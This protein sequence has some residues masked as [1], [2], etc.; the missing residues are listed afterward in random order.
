MLADYHVHTH[1]SGDSNYIMEEVV[2][3]A[4]SIGFKEI[5]FTDHVDYFKNAHSHLIDY[6]A[7]N[8]EYNRLKEKYKNEIILKCGIEFGIQIHTIPEFN[9]DFKNNNFDFVILSNHQIDDT[10]FWNYEYQKGKKQ[11]QYNQDY[12]M[13]ILDVIT[14]YKDYSVLGHL[15]MIK[16]YDQLGI[17]DDSINE[18]LIKSI[19]KKVISDGKGIEV[20]TSCFRYGLN[21]LTPS[22]TILNWYYELGGEILTIG[23]DSHKESDLGHNIKQVKEEL[24]NIEFKKFCTFDKM[25]PIFHDLT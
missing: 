3:R 24:K 23:S 10:E 8:K 17:L 5:C 1:F 2:K 21:D 16:R 22:R 19:L 18:E 9:N 11:L 14:N 25:V 20:N 6:E 15:D 7:Y 4:I 12:Y 13:A